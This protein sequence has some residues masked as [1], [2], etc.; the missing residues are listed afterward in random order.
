MC[1]KKK[2]NS[3]WGVFFLVFLGGVFSSKKALYKF[4]EHLFKKL[5]QVVNMKINFKESNQAKCLTLLKSEI[6]I[7]I[8]LLN[9]SWF[10]FA[11][12]Y[13]VLFKRGYY[14]LF[15]PFKIASE[16]LFQN[17]FISSSNSIV[18]T[19]SVVE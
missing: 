3:N 4:L 18:S 5:P 6:Y 10:V 17:L 7:F 13:V 15:V 8:Y 11:Y 19:S 12:Q 9:I 2:Q 14:I 1:A 16:N